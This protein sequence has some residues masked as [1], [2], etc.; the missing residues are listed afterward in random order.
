MK[1]SFLRSI[2]AFVIVVS[3]LTTPILAIQKKGDKNYKQGLKHEVAERWDKAAEEFALAVAANPG[4]AEFRLHYIRA[5]FNASQM[6]MQRGRTLAEQKDY[7]GAYNAFR[8]AYGYDPVNELAKSE[9]ERMLRLQ[10]GL[11]PKGEPQN[12]LPKDGTNT[13][14]PSPPNVKV[15]PTSYTASGAPAVPMQDPVQVEQLRDIRYTKVDLKTVVKDLAQ[16]LDLNI[17]FDTQSFNRPRDITIELKN[18]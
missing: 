18:G 1:S 6:M 16:T 14:P 10:E 9:M 2:A 11:P 12:Q 15:V 17:L 5:L 4:N 13:P 8:Q 3:L 7:V